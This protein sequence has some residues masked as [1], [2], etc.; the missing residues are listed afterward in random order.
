[1]TCYVKK[2]PYHCDKRMSLKVTFFVKSLS[3]SYVEF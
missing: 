2:K 1:M 3:S